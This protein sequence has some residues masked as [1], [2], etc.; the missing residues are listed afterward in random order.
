MLGCR[1]RTGYWG[2]GEALWLYLM[3]QSVIFFMDD[4]DSDKFISIFY[5][6]CYSFFSSYLFLIIIS[7]FFSFSLYFSLFVAESSYILFNALSSLHS[8]YN[9]VNLLANFL[10]LLIFFFKFS[11]FSY[12]ILFIPYSRS[13]SCFSS[14]VYLSI[15]SSLIRL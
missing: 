6:Y 12:F 8:S 15:S 5:I 10:F 13:A 14:C 1:T 11:F 2:S 7:L 4:Q 3:S 9:S